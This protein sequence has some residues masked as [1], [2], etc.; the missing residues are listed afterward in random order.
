MQNYLKKKKQKDRDKAGY[1]PPL[2]DY[3]CIKCHQSGAAINCPM[4]KCKKRICH[5]CFKKYF[6]DSVSKPNFLLLHHAFCQKNGFPRQSLLKPINKVMGMPQ[7][8]YLEEW[9]K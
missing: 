6:V 7:L 1:P 8:P 9:K 4:N 5:I 3:K 2:P